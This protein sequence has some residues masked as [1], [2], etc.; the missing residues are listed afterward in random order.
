MK[1]FTFA[2]VCVCSLLAQA[3]PGPPGG[4][5]TYKQEIGDFLLKKDTGGLRFISAGANAAALGAA[6]RAWTEKSESSRVRALAAAAAPGS[7]GEARL[8]AALVDWTGDGRIKTPGEAAAFLNDAADKAVADQALER[9]RAMSEKEMGGASG[10]FGR[11]RT[12]DSFVPRAI[13][14]GRFSLVGEKKPQAAAP[15]KSPLWL[16]RYDLETLPGSAGPRPVSMPEPN[17]IRN[18]TTKAPNKL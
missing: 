7:K 18:D 11:D 8:V 6:A 10:V 16:L 15:A 14:G 2:L 1:P 9:A 4:Q 17:P 13:V 3:Q 5:I 12:D